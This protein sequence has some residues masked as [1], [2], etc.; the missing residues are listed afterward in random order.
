VILD[1]FA[2]VDRNPAIVRRQDTPLALAEGVANGGD[3]VGG[4][5]DIRTEQSHGEYFGR[6]W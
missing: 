2:T 6:G 4:Q 1:Q 5:M 3:V